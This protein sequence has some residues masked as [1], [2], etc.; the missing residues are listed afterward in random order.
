MLQPWP[1]VRNFGGGG[2]NHKRPMPFGF[3]QDATLCQPKLMKKYHCSTYQ[4]NRWREEL[5]VDT[6]HRVNSKPVFQICIETGNVIERHK[7]MN[8]AARAIGGTFQNIDKA[9]KGIYRQA[10]GFNWRF[11]VA[12]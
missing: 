4:I 5:G 6:M 12:N 10:Y 8:A 11:D 1:V 9:A 3:E 7:S 2:V